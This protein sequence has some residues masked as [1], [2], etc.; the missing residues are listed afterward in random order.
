MDQ[1]IFISYRRGDSEGYAVRIFDRLQ[2]HFGIDRVFMDVTDIS[3]R[4]NFKDA[5]DQAI[6]SCRVVILIIGPRW[7]SITDEMGRNRLDDPHDFVRVEV[8]AALDHDVL[9]VPVLVHRG[10]M[11]TSEDLPYD[12]RALAQFVA[13]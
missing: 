3:V 4:E 10:K 6:S 5:I 9:I 13:D 2:D 1:N 7:E 12:L 8:Q 11:P